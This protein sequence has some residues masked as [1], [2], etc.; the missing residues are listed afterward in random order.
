MH[1]FDSVQEIL[2]LLQPYIS[3]FGVAMA[4]VGFSFM[5][6]APTPE[7]QVGGALRALQVGVLIAL[8]HPMVWVVSQGMR[9][10]GAE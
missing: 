1:F 8:L 7:L 10:L 2:T 9:W 5:Q 4:T 6:K 3:I